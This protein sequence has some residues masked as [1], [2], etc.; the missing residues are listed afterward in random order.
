MDATDLTVALPSVEEEFADVTAFEFLALVRL[1]EARA[2]FDAAVGSSHDPDAETLRFSVVPRLAFPPGEVASLSRNGDGRMSV[3]V[4]LPGLTGPL[5]V[6]PRHYT[7]LIRS[8]QAKRDTALGD[9]LDL[10]HHRLLSLFYR[11]WSRHRPGG[12]VGNG[13]TLAR[14]LL[15]VVGQGTDGLHD[16]LPV[17]ADMIRS[18]AGLL[19]PT[20][21]SAVALEQLL[22]D[23]FGVPVSVQQFVGRWYALED[24]QRTSLDEPGSDTLGGLSFG[25]MVGDA[26]WD[27]ESSIT[28]RLGPLTREQYDRFLPDGDDYPV[29]QSLVRLQT[30]DRVSADACLILRDVEVPGTRLTDPGGRLGYGTWL[31][32]RQAMNDAGDTVITL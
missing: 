28:I 2:P 26:V 27:T 17:D 23:A 7:E 13:E 30:D 6:L 12:R 25:A 19:G 1:L 20:Q 3:A 14:H 15:D 29:L 21:R 22:E 32:A 10:F 8:R 18:R 9:F 16:T 4:H 31:R 24:S 5:G 11:G